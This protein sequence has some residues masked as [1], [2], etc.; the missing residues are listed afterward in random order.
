M[1][2]A[3]RLKA[4]EVELMP[5]AWPRFERFIREVAKAGPRHRPSKTK[6]RSVSR[7]RIRKG[8]TDI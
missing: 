1:K 3:K 5:D 8:K 6:T 2:K 4:T 7:G